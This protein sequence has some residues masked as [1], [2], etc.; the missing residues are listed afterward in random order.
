MTRLNKID[1]LTGGSASPNLK[2][3]H[4]NHDII[5]KQALHAERGLRSGARPA[6]HGPLQEPDRESDV[7]HSDHDALTGNIR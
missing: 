2:V 7:R 3:Q 5:Y 6:S 1:L 4:L